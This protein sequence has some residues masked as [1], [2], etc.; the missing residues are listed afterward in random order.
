M[1][2]RNP[3]AANPAPHTAGRGASGGKPNRKWLLWTLIAVG[4]SPCWLPLLI[5]YSPVIAPAAAGVSL[6]LVV[7]RARRKKPAR[8]VALTP[9]RRSR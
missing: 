5:L 6:V 7:V 9:A 1:T 2:A 3:Y 4:T 8:R